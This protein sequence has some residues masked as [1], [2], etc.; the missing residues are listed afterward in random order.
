MYAQTAMVENGFVHLPNAAPW[1]AAYLHKLTTFPNGRHDDQVPP[2]TSSRGDGANA[3]L[4]QTRQRP[5]FQRWIFEL[6][7]MRADEAR[8]QQAAH[9][10][11][12][13]SARSRRHPPNEPAAPERRIDGAVEMPE[14]E[15]QSFLRAG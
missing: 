5:E 10:A 2:G 11:P 12:P 4:V 14:S 1:L 8:R 7:R 9:R 15:A 6:Y 3:R 13:A